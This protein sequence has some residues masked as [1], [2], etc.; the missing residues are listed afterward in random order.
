MSTTFYVE[1]EE[2]EEEEEEV[3]KII[4]IG[5]TNVGKSCLAHRFC[6]GTFPERTEATIGVDFWERRLT[7]DQRKIKVGFGFFFSP[8]LQVKTLL[9]KSVS[10]TRLI[11]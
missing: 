6:K 5:D 1:G 7:L 11:S 9:Y 4:V 8:A 2:Q 3:F 10:D